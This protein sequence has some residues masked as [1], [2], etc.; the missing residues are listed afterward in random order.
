MQKTKGEI[1]KERIYITAKEMFYNKGY[2]KTTMKDI[3]DELDISLGNLTY[4]FKTKDTIVI[5][6]FADYLDN[7]YEFIW[8]KV[9]SSADAYY[10]HFF[11][12][13]VFYKVILTNPNNKRFF[14]EIMK[15]KS[16]YKLLSDRISNIYQGF[17]QDYHLRVSPSQYKGILLADFGA[18]REVMLSYL[19]GTIKMPIED[20]AILIFS[21]TSKLLGI[22]EKIIFKTS[23][24]AY[25]ASKQYDYSQIKL[26]I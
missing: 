5:N 14:G 18:R 2:K 25:T 8:D 16:F 19:E 20:L 10:K 22:H 12:T 26:L 4:H 21:N 9:D 17:I 15:T 3:A 23:H 13:I 6:I 1:T 24:N 7:I 11:V